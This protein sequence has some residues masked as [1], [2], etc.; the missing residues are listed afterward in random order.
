MATDCG[1]RIVEMVWEDLKPRDI[2][3][4]K[5]FDNAVTVLMALGGSTNAVVHLIAMAG[6]AGVK[7]TARRLRRGLAQ[8][9]RCICNLRPSGKYLM[10]DFYYAGGLRAL[11][12]RAARPAAPRRAAPSTARR[13]ARTSPAPRS[14]TTTSSARA[15]T[16]CRPRAAWRCCAATS[17]PTARSSRPAPASR[18]LLTHTGPAVVFDDYNDLAARIDDEDLPSTPDSVLVLRNAGPLGGPGMP[19][20]GMLP[21]PKKLLKQGVRDMV[22]I[23]D[24]RMSG[25]SY[26]TCVLHVAPESFVGGPLALVRDGDLIELDVPDRAPRPEGRRGRA[27]PPPRR[28]EAAGPA[29][30]ARLRRDVLPP[31]HPGRQGLRL[32]LPRGHRARARAGDPLAGTGACVAGTAV[33]V[34]VAMASLV[35]GS[36]AESGARRAKNRDPGVVVR[37]FLLA[38]VTVAGGCDPLLGTIQVPE[39]AAPARR[40]VEIPASCQVTARGQT[41]HLVTF[42]FRNVGSRTLFLASCSYQVVISSCT[43]GYQDQLFQ[44]GACPCGIGCAG[45]GGPACSN[46]VEPVLAGGASDVVWEA[47]LS[48]LDRDGLCAVAY[49]DFPPGAT[50]YPSRFMPRL[51]ALGRGCGRGRRSAGTSTWWADNRSWRSRCR[52]TKHQM[53]GPGTEGGDASCY[54]PAL[55]LA[56]AAAGGAGS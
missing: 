39:Y 41:P 8:A 48:V 45:V 17:R 2:L 43:G 5:S 51:K 36:P 50:G 22:R 52:W 16:R 27:G 54:H 33:A 44:P 55:V 13:W 6:R 12:G 21:I 35:V 32:R 28:L 10:E 4:R 9:R 26:G 53:A 24:A 49:Q 3:T 40:V 38:C 1:R 23:S 47:S 14:T 42:R 29:L 31:H 46:S 7:L 56:C 20:W 11:L 34:P 15:T 18:A 37:S 19:E 25:T 30:P